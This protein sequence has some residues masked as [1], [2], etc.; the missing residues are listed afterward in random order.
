MHEVPNIARAHPI[1]ARW[2]AESS[3]VLSPKLEF[4]QHAAGALVPH[5]QCFRADIK[6]S[7]ASHCAALW[8]FPSSVV[9]LPLSN[10]GGC[11]SDIRP[12]M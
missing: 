7:L 6:L 4:T 12:H 2:P 11:V 10:E 5:E 9:F 8:A 3:G 1:V